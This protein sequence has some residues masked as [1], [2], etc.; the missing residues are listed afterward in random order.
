MDSV[1]IKKVISTEPFRPVILRLNNGVEYPVNRP[2]EL[3]MTSNG[4]VLFYFDKD[5]GW[6]MIDHY[7]IVEVIRPS[8]KNGGEYPPGE[9]N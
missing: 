7:A 8:G 4:R 6:T 9:E 1:D 3:G 2:Q 5:G